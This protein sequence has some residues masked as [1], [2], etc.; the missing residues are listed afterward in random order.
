MTIS[1]KLIAPQPYDFAATVR[2]HGWIALLPFRWR[3][4]GVVQ[5]VERLDSGNVVLL[6]ISVNSKNIVV[7]VQPD[8]L[9]AAEEAEI[10]RKVSWMLRLDEDF[11]EFYMF[12]NRAST[13]SARVSSG[14]GRLLRSSSIFEDTIKTICTTNTTWTQT[15]GMVARLVNRLGDPFPTNPE[16]RA[17]PTPA[18][19]A[20][21][22]D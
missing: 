22:G 18:Q 20:A 16:L 12:A 6:E 13:L 5:R 3:D 1:L 10:R 4:D 9:T 21:A 7:A 15:K 14:R 11:S 17:F 8:G 19:I 2:D